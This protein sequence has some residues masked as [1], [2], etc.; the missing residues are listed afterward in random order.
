[1]S[2]IIRESE[3]NFSNVKCF[4]RFLKQSINIRNLFDWITRNFNF[5]F[6]FRFFQWKIVDLFFLN[7]I[8]F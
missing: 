1:M 3:I 7:L 4:K 6:Y 8:L 2:I 5:R